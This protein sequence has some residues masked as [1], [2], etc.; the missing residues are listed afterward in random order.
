MN[1]QILLK[2]L[3]K[4]LSSEG[5]ELL[6]KGFSTW[7]SLQFLKDDEISH[8]VKHGLGTVRNFNRL[9]GIATLVCEIN[10]SPSEA[11]LLMHSGVASIK[12]LANLTPQELLQT[13]GRLERQLNTG[14]IPKVDLT[15][16]NVWIQRAKTGKS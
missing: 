6:S 7:K 9:R 14:R 15:K 5:K 10:L 8:F 13:T 16:A 12:A 2:E 4:N 1:E 11:A 3:P